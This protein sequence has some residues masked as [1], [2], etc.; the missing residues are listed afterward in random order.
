[1][2]K[3]LGFKIA[4]LVT[5]VATLV[6]N[7]LTTTG[8]TSANGTSVLQPIGNVSDQFDTLITPPGWAFSIWGLIYAGLLIFT[9]A[10]FIPQLKLDDYVGKVSVFFILSCLFNITW[11]VAFSLATKVS[12]LIS[13]FLIFGLLISLIVIQLRCTFFSGKNTP[14]EIGFGDIPISIYLGWLMTASI[15]NVAVCIRAWTESS[16]LG[17][18]NIWYIIIVIVA[19]ILYIL[20]MALKNNYVTMVVFFYVLIALA[21]KHQNDTVL[22]PF[23]LAILSF[24]VF[25]LIIKAVLPSFKR[26]AAR[27][28]MRRVAQS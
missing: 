25:G 13:V 28:V 21:V 26:L 8:V 5:F 7:Y 19:A 24:C 12:I 1:M 14:F 18:E 11:I 22:F 17:N 6:V 16:Q 23:T 3:I 2:N 9:I 15:L 20:N 4:N 10:Q 27:F